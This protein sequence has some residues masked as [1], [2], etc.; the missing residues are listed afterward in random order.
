MFKTILAGVDG[1]ETCDV[2]FR[3]TLELAQSLGAELILLGVLI[4]IGRAHV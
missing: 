2:V 4:Q 1:G 3:K